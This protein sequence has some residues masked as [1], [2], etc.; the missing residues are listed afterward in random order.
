[1]EERF[2]DRID[3]KLRSRMGEELKSNLDKLAAD[4]DDLDVECAASRAVINCL[5]TDPGYQMIGI[6][7]VVS[8]KLQECGEISKD[9]RTVE[10]CKLLAYYL[11]GVQ[12]GLETWRNNALLRLGRNWRKP[13]P[14]FMDR[15]DLTLFAQS[16]QKMPRKD[17]R[18][19][20]S[21]A[22]IPDTA[23]NGGAAHD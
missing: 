3:T 19:L 17:F 15:E 6:V 8:G 20:C 16:L 1:M 7:A 23:E 12:Q 21:L 2:N 5:Q 22:G 4:L 13:I 18:E 10:L 11:L 9:P 14:F